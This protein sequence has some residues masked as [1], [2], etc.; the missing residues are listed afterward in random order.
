MKPLPTIST[1]RSCPIC[2]G[3]TYEK[4]AD[5]RKYIIDDLYKSPMFSWMGEIIEDYTFDLTSDGAPSTED[6]FLIED[7]K[8]DE[9]PSAG[10][11]L[12]TKKNKKGKWK[13]RRQRS[14][15]Y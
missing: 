12:S 8:S 5:K 2:G 15:K 9:L 11:R 14:A 4:F 1:E 6:R 13:T 7:Y 3:R 10:K